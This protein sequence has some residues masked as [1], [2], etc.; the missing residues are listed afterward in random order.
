MRMNLWW[1]NEV[2]YNMNPLW[3]AMRKV[4]RNKFLYRNCAEFSI[5]IH[6]PITTGVVQHDEIDTTVAS[7][8]KNIFS[9]C[10]P[11]NLKSF[12]RKTHTHRLRKAGS[13]FPS[14]YF[15]VFNILQSRGFWLCIASAREEKAQS[16][17]SYFSSAN[18]DFCSFLEHA[19]F[20]QWMNTRQ[21]LHL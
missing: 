1:A 11:K 5:K 19:M 21:Y 12:R 20:I 9:E 6:V 2:R 18:I 3:C 14:I 17:F 15:L 4:C 16:S 7:A 13:R 8:L 10:F